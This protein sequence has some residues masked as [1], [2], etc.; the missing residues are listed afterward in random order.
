MFQLINIRLPLLAV[1]F[2]FVWGCM[3]P[4]PPVVDESPNYPPKFQTPHYLAAREKLI[5]SLVPEERLAAIRTLDNMMEFMAKDRCESGEIL[6]RIS[7]VPVSVYNKTAFTAVDLKVPGLESRY[8]VMARPFVIQENHVSTINL[9][10]QAYIGCDC[11]YDSHYPEE[12]YETFWEDVEKLSRLENLDL[13]SGVRLTQA[14]I[15][16]KI[17][18]SRKN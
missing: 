11:C 1:L 4:E 5:E 10:V 14:E 15:A 3:A 18:G 13:E 9:C 17:R 16:E 7:D 8:S 2:V 12:Y 6:V